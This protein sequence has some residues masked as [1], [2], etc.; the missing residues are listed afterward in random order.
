MKLVTYNI[1]YGKG[2]DDRFDL[3]RITDAIGGADIIGLQEVD[4]YWHRSGY[5]DQASILAELFP[6]YLW[7][8][9]PGYDAPARI[10]HLESA[11]AE[12]RGRRRQHGNMILSRWPILSTRILPLPKA[13][14]QQFCQLRVMLEAVINTPGGAMRVYCTHLCHISPKTRLPQVEQILHHLRMLRHEGA[15]WS[16]E[17]LNHHAWGDG[18]AAPPYPDDVVFMG[19]LNMTPDAGEY[20]RLINGEADLQDSWYM[21]DYDPAAPN[22]YSCLSLK[23]QRTLRLDY[24]FVSSGLS[25]RLRKSWIDQQTIASDHYPVW[26][27]FE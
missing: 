13:K 14:L 17:N 24:I 19:D 25:G 21:L 11:G 26:L 1:H 20:Q 6:G 5:R 22:A 27:E 8:Y 12:E 23:D 15:T 7:V 10:E 16:G 4:R 9:A 2:Q 3:P 18:D